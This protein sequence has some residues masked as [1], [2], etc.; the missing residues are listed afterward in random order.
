MSRMICESSEYAQ[1]IQPN[2]FLLPD[3]LTYLDFFLH[4]L[5]FLE[6]LQ[7]IVLSCPLWIYMN[8]WIDVRFYKI[9]LENIFFNLKIF[10]LEF[11]VVDKR[12]INLGKTKR[13]TPCITCTCTTEGVC[14]KFN[15]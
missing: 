2:A 6:M 7:L 5:Y 10:F 4:I 1:K 3:E 11:C 13:I 14:L 15:L 8:G 12:V 9:F